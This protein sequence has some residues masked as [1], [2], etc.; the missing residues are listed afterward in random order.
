MKTK[1]GARN[2]TFYMF[3]DRT[4]SLSGG[5]IPSRNVKYNVIKAKH[6]RVNFV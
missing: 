2:L 4:Y 1:Q 6:F 3:K 5:P